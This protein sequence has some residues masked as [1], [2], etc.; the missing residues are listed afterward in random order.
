MSEK[1]L[2]QV[3]ADLHQTL[4]NYWQD[5][6]A[7][8][9]AYR[10]DPED[11]FDLA[12]LG[13][14]W[15]GSDFV[16]QT[17]IRRPDVIYQLLKQDISLDRNLND[18]TRQVQS[19][20]SECGDASV[21][22]REK[23]VKIMQGLRQLRQQEMVRIAW[24]DLASLVSPE[25]IL[26]E[27]SDLAEVMVAQTLAYIETDFSRIHGQPVNSM[28]EPVSLVVL[29]M[30]KMGGRELNFSSDIDLILAYAEDGETPG[31]RCTSHHEF[32]LNVA[33]K[34][35]KYLHEVTVDGFVYRVDTRLRPHGDSGPLVI[36]FSGMEQ[37]YQLQGRNWERYAM[38][39]AR[40][41]TG[42]ASQ[43]QHLQEILTPF[44]YRRYLDYSAFE[45][46]REMKAMIA[47]QMKRKG[48]RDNVKLGPGGIR[49]IEFIGQTFQLLRGGR[50][51]ALRRRSIIAVIS[52]LVE[53]ELLT[54][55]EAS[56]LTEAYW[57]LRR[58]ENRIQMLRDQQTHI[59]PG[60]V[61]SQSRLCVAMHIPDWLQLRQRLAAHQEKVGHVFDA[62]IAPDEVKEPRSAGIDAMLLFWGD[63]EHSDAIDEWLT[64]TGYEDSNSLMVALQQ[65]RKSPGIRSLSDTGSNRLAQLLV[66]LIE[67]AAGSGQA[68]LV[69]SR[70]LDVLQSI[71]GR[72]VY[73]SMLNEYPAL[74]SQLLQLIEASDWF[75]QS[76]ARYPLLLDSLL[77]TG[78]LFHIDENHVQLLSGQLQQV[79]SQRIRSQQGEAS[80]DMDHRAALVASHDDV[81]EEQMDRLR[82]FKQQMI[83]KV[84]ILD[85]FYQLPVEKV[86]DQLSAT[87][88][89]ILQQVLNISWQAMVARYGEPECIIDGERLQ[90][91]LSIIGYGKLGGD[92]LGY[93]SD[94]DIIFLHNSAGEKQHTNGEKSIDNQRFFARVAQRMVHI[95]TAQTYAGYLY[96]TDTR[97]RPN[98]QSGMMVSS[99]QAFELYQQEKA[100]TWEHQALIRARFIAGNAHVEQEFDRI[101]ASVL[102]RQRDAQ[103]V[104]AEVVQMR[105]KMRAHLGSKTG[106]TQGFD[107]DSFDL[108]QDAGGLVDIEFLVQAGV[109]I[110]AHK[111]KSLLTSS[112][113]LV[114]IDLLLTAGW[115]NHDEA[116]VLSEVYRRFRQLKN[117]QNL[118]C[119][120]DLSEIQAD[121][122]KVVKV[123][124]RLM[125]AAVE[126]N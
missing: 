22:A 94:L 26:F 7:S 13:Q 21:N 5:W 71:A 8:C 55:E 102:S 90:P 17:C 120:T 95:L 99:L 115:F 61:L 54:A 43:R 29:A 6:V 59:L 30:G 85:V 16:A 76:I 112:A 126:K 63:A 37:Y 101:R 64:E 97:L 10:I 106:T 93:G 113:T 32:F 79:D 65:F 4:Q 92:E 77:N 44:I 58:L 124:H 73:I 33:R 109:L 46:I 41:I 52:V 47:A 96:E 70:V 108:K 74:Q 84:A 14:I 19:I 88:S 39:K 116:G 105:E 122:E 125:P 1:L 107:A 62:L 89:A 104:L 45:S 24:R 103:A 123:W 31:P 57:F 27:L 67:K 82:Q 114:L 50:E 12:L 81:L 36:S 23:D 60:D 86:G 121:S 80:P 100:W 40:M 117:W 18:Y 98:G 20:L 38:I 49:E 78:D 28:G 91:G 75:A 118:K 72:S 66:S 68:A 25:Q 15:A 34:L 42:S 53:A 110:H 9:E 35:I 119:K 11:G 87:A 69:V 51:L 111:D 3:P 2:G 56:S 48:M 83:F